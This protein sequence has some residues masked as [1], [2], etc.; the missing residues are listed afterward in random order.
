MDTANP[1]FLTI[2]ERRKGSIEAGKLADLVVLSGD[3]MTFPE[4]AIKDIQPLATMPGG[5][6]VHS[7]S[8]GLGT[9]GVLIE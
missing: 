4:P 9:R 1:A 8:E 3:P 6:V 2:E 5:K 7:Q